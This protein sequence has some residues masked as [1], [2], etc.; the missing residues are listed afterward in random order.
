MYLGYYVPVLIMDNGKNMVQPRKFD[1]RLPGS[2]NAR[3]DNLDGF[4]RKQFRYTPQR[5]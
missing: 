4:W 5:T 3:L 2:Y 1:V